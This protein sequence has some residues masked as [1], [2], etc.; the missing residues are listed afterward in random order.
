MADQLRWDC[1]STYGHPLLDTP[2]IDWLAQNGVRFDRAY[3]Q[4]PICGPSRMSFYT[5]RYVSS[6]GSTCND[7]PL[8]ADER[9]LGDHL[10]RLG[11]ETTL[12]GKTHM[13][14]DRAG[15]K[16]LNVPGNSQDAVRAAECGF[17]IFFREEG[18][19]PKSLEDVPEKHDK[20]LYNQWLK[21]Q[22]Y[23]GPNPWENW[24]NS[25]ED[26]NGNIVS[27]WLLS[28][29]DRPARVKEQH[30]E[31]PYLT[32]KAIECIKEK[33]A[34][35]WCIHVSYI[36]PHWPYIVPAPYH[37]L[38]KDKE[39]PLPI[40]GNAERNNPHPVY[41]ALMNRRV[42]QAFSRD[43]IRANVLPAYFG[44][45]KQLDDQI[46]VLL[47]YLRSS[48][49]INDTMIVFTSDHGDYLGDHWLGEKDFFHESSVRVPLII[50][51][52]SS[53]ANATRGTASPHLVEAI[54]IV[55]TFVERLGGNT[56]QWMEGHSLLPIL[57]DNKA[58][59]LRETV[60]SE[61]DYAL[62]DFRL[63]TSSRV[64]DAAMTM[65]LTE[66]W[67]YVHFPNYRP[68]LFDLKE[69]PQELRDLGA[70]SGSQTV[71]RDMRDR[72]SEWALRSRRVTE[73]TQSLRERSN[74]QATRGIILG[75]WD[76]AD[77][78]DTRRE[79][80][81]FDKSPRRSTDRMSHKN[82]KGYST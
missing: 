48:G 2:N 38:Y 71:L 5:G 52:P 29:S 82:N 1:L 54:D 26:D 34:A 70:D 64:E 32:Q 65:A 22:G 75:A 46:G 67:K 35:P 53:D 3:V 28:A 69:D 61:Y 11:V 47:D 15:L 43:D 12:V 49:Q 50:Y 33:G 57:R 79:E 72:L 45:I 51:D 44:L 37:S 20:A 13:R 60:F 27:G 7:V 10:R 36:K 56:D 30:S 40:R 73:S 41:Q 18:I 81:E 19:Y 74:S 66:K 42:S 14:A 23:G 78:A 68:M 4:S 62:M 17:D 59:A 24:V 55:P 58:Q 8:R 25:V 39:L 80:A 63:D 31:T 6:H 16:R 76:A 9:T 21:E 77:V